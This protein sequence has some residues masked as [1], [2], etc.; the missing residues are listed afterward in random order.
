MKREQLVAL[1]RLRPR[2]AIG[3]SGGMV[4]AIIGTA[5]VQFPS[6]ADAQLAVGCVQEF[7]P[8]F[9]ELEALKQQQSPGLVDGMVAEIAT[10]KTRL[11]QEAVKYD[12]LL[13]DLEAEIIAHAK[14]RKQ[15]KAGT[16]VARELM[17]VSKRA[18]ALEKAL[19]AERNSKR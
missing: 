15:A 6:E 1:A 19:A 4:V 3:A 14:T 16:T 5:S 17:K 13:Y 12:R 7:L 10:L 18:D 2:P 8:M 11:A 9:D